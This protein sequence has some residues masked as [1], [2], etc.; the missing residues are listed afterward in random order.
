M[1]T[2]RRNER[3][4]STRS[5]SRS[6]SNLS[7]D[8]AHREYANQ[9]QVPKAS[10]VRIIHRDGSEEIKDAKAFLRHSEAGRTRRVKYARE[11]SIRPKRKGRVWR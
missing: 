7:S 8:Y 1:S 9:W 11:Y 10:D 2:S 5:S 4:R 6:T 3:R